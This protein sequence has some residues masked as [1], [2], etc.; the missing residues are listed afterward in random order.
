M[1]KM[2]EHLK[3]KISEIILSNIF[4]CKNFYYGFINELLTK[5]SNQSESV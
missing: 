1:Y 3:L 4:L 2:L 5:N